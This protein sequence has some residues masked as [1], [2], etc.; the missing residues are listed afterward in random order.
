MISAKD[1]V[2]ESNKTAMQLASLVTAGNVLNKTLITQVKPQL[3]M[4]MRG[5][6]DHALAEVV[7]A[8]LASFAVQNFDSDNK[9][10]VIATEAMMAAAMGSFMASFNIEEIVADVLKDVNLPNMLDE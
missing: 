8:N 2:V 9:Q 6:A 10:A 7:L 3:P 4:L 5:Y 1:K